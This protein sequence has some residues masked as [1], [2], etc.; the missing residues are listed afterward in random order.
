MLYFKIRAFRATIVREKLFTAEPLLR[1]L[2]TGLFGNPVSSRWNGVLNP[3]P[4]RLLHSNFLSFI[5]CHI[6][7]PGCKISL[8]LSIDTSQK[9]HHL[10]V[11]GIQ[12][13]LFA[14]AKIGC[15][16]RGEDVN[17]RGHAT[18]GGCP[19]HP[20]RTPPTR[21]DHQYIRQGNKICFQVWVGSDS[22]VY[23]IQRRPSMTNDRQN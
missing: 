18:V 16:R 14:T 23:G 1:W 11:R 6:K 15:S 12:Y 3:I 5:S 13:R 7:D 2:W 21:L 17:G 9:P 4:K 8:L 20:R 19:F 10:T 22:N